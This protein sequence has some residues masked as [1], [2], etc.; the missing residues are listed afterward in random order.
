M[1]RICVFTRSTPHHLVGGMEIISWNLA[2]KFV[3]RGHQVQLIKTSVSNKPGTFKEEG[4]DVVVLAGTS[5]AS[6]QRFG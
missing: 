4:I 2:K 5:L 6:I 1:L 3:Q